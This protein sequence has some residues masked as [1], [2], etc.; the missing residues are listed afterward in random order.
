MKTRRSFCV[1]LLAISFIFTPTR[2]DEIG[3]KASGK[4]GAVAAGGAGAVAAGIS[5]LEQ[6]GNAADAAAATLLALS[7]TDYGSYTI[8]AEIPLII[9]DARNEQVKVL[10]GLG[11]APLDPKTIEWFYENGIPSR[12]G[13]K[14]APVPGALSL[15]MTTVKLYGTMSFEQ[16]AGPSLE[17]LDSG[18]KDWYPNLARTF[19]R[20][21]ET[22]KETRGDRRRKLQAA[23]DRF[24]KGDIA[25]ELVAYYTENGG[26]LRKQD[27]AAHETRVEK[28]VKVNYRSYTVCKCDTWTQGPYL[29]QTLRLLEGFDLK[30][31]GHLSADYV[32]VL[33]EALKLGLADR[34]KYYG[35]PLFVDVPL[36][37]LLS[38]RYTNLRRSLIDMIKASD[39]V[40]PGDPIAMKAVVAADPY[41]PWQGGTTTCVVA[42]RWGNMVSATPSGNRPY[43]VCEELGIGH[44]NRL[45]SLNTTIGHPNRIQPGKRPRIT[46]TPTIVLKNGEPIIA[47]SVAGGDLQD[48]TTLNCLLNHVE[49]GMM[50]ADAVTAVRFSTNHRQN[51]FDPNS[52]RTETLGTL[53]SLTVNAGL[54]E[55]VR[56]ELSK[57]G[58]K[59][60][61]TD[62]PIAYPVMIYVDP[63]TGII[64][65][66]GDPKAGRHAAAID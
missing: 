51:S 52:I 18:G 16:V 39:E 2:A 62:R 26:F 7:I 50:P 57:R 1:F 40:R 13:I 22:E 9:Y 21:I 63:D 19:R 34:D 20:L 59:I 32:H 55:S 23:R 28:P 33:T 64:H 14:A 10:C 30:E 27:L 61:T 53:A 25:D 58:H 46:L 47:I 4:G 17:L 45:R 37:A 48:Q 66:A 8:G 15:C 44:G 31:M 49:F 11:G 41:R 36:K 24:Y 43:A 29:C 6:G 38:D 35:D 60:K 42:D 65:A 5:I 56:D 3:W 12:G 54:D